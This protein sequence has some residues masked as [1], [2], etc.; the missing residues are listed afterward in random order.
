M[1]Q[2]EAN[3]CVGIEYS[4]GEIQTANRKKTNSKRQTDP[5]WKLGFVFWNL[6]FDFWN[7][8]KMHIRRRKVKRAVGWNFG[9]PA[10][11]KNVTQPFR[12]NS[13]LRAS[14]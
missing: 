14:R 8:A 4:E 11:A 12:A 1:V 10:L 5:A 9:V 3:T 7:F 13:E 6:H 2:T